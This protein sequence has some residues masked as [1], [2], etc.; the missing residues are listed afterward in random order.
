MRGRVVVLGRHLAV[1]GLCQLFAWRFGAVVARGPFGR[2]SP[3]LA[4]DPGCAGLPRGPFPVVVAFYHLPV[5]G[6]VFVAFVVPLAAA[7]FF[8]VVSV[9]STRL[10]VLPMVMVRLRLSGR[11]RCRLAPLM[12]MLP[13]R[14]LVALSLV[15]GW[16]WG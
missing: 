3:A 12:V 13:V 11:A 6:W 10:P 9:P 5:V 7:G 16:S 2:L 14:A 4:V 15:A 8:L 1:V